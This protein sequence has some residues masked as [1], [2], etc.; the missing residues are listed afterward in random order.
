VDGY[1]R[2]V[3]EQANAGIF[4][5][6]EDPA[7]LA[8]AITRLAADPALCE[9]LGRNGRQHVLQHFSR[10]RTAGTYLDILRDLLGEDQSC[11]AAA[12]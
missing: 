3:M 8:E 4:I 12:A 1:A 10:R 5:Q 2:Q 6:P 9:S 7:D 11:P